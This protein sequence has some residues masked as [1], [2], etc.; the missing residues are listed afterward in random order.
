MAKK[1][2]KKRDKATNLQNNL[3]SSGLCKVESPQHPWLLL[4]RKLNTIDT[5]LQ[6]SKKLVA[7][8]QS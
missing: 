7:G 2:S 4:M 3:G 6:E 1:K 8:W 5:L